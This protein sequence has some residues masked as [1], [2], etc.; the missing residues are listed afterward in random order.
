MRE[1]VAVVRAILAG[2]DP[3]DGERFRSGFRLAGVE[4]RPEI[5]IYL[6]ALSPGM[7]RAAGEIADG[8][9]LWTCVPE[10]VRDVVVPEVAEGRRRAG[11]ELDGFDIVPAIPTAVTGEPDEAR[12]KLRQDLIPYFSLPFYRAML[13]R[14]GYSEEIAGVDAGMQKGDPAAATAAISDRYLGSL[15][16]I[17]DA[18]EADGALRRYFEAGATSPCVGPVA[19]TDFDATL[20]ALAGIGP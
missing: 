5:P 11:K 16:A 1:Y 18:E 8:V 12:A 6:G 10:Y 15:A 19:K 9:I 4:P 17:G 14:S 13:E 7:L 2:E 3:P 20:E